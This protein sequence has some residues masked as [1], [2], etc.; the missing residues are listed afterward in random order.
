MPA[1]YF[2]DFF[3]V[4]QV[5]LEK[6]GALDISLIND[7][8]L[9]IDP[10]L[11][12]GSRKDEYRRLHQEIIKYIIFLRDKS[13]TGSL[14][15]GL[16]SSWF[17]FPEEK[18]NWLGYSETGNKGHGLGTTFAR[19]LNVNLVSIFKDFGDEDI[20]ESSHLEKLG[21][22]K[23]GVGKDNISD[24][25][26]NLI[27]KFLLE[28]TQTFATERIDSKYLQDIAVDKVYFDYELEKWIGG[29]FRLPIFAGEYVI[30]TPKDML[31]K[32]ETWINRNDLN[33]RFR[34]I[35]NSIPDS[36]LRDQLNNYLSKAIFS[37]DVKRQREQEKR[38]IDELLATHPEIL[39]YYLKERE[40]HKEYAQAFSELKVGTIE[41][42]LIENVKIIVS[43]LKDRTDF[44]KTEGDSYEAAY[45]RVIYLKDFIEKHDG[46]RL[47]YDGN[48]PINSESNLQLIYRLTW[49]ATR[50]DLNRETNNGRGPVDYAVSEGK[51]DKSLVEFKLASNSKLEQN[52]KNQVKIYEDANKTR[53]SVKAIMYY[54]E[55]ELDKLIKI[56]NMLNL[57]NDP[58]IIII[59]ATPKQSASNLK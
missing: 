18:G 40:E 34:A 9:F 54:K 19:A 17:T 35:L 13:R 1:I 55:S 29:L 52:L 12:F 32:D 14:S 57:Q 26:T 2:S 7:L 39:N 37:E 10:F 16:V 24:L 33:H 20:L 23:T 50:F 51:T 38:A 3:N 25:T 27:K 11:L 30:L 45:N 5:D 56:L 15:S 59:D 31:T 48:T 21:L 36:N 28:Y 42:L 43:Y 22:I 46:W 6:Y 41:K 53:K 4:S 58:S 44:Y 8:P 47:F 49:Y